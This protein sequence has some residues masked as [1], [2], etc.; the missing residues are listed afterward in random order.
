MP[1]RTIAIGDIHGCA[2]ALNALLQAIKIQPNDTI[3]TLGDYCDRGPDT[4][5]VIDRLMKLQR[6]CRLVPLLGNHDQLMHLVC[7]GR[8]ELMADWWLAGGDRALASYGS[9]TTRTV[10]KAHLEFL[11]NCRLTY[12]TERFFFAHGGYDPHRPLDAQDPY[13]VLWSR[14]KDGLPGPHFSGK[15][16]IV[17]HFR[18]RSGE[19]LDL[20]HLKCIDTQC[21]DGG[22]L[23]A[24][25]PETGRVW[26]ASRR[27]KLRGKKK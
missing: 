4:R 13:V 20:G 16:A 15:T 1:G 8:P 17:G 21:F 9:H 6:E 5:G 3:V 23:T 12:E 25:E 14:A 2:R 19:I 7:N 11:R 26:Q 18:Q 27:G 22:W 24:L 10:P